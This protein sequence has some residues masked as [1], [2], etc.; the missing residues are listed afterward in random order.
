M[1]YD[2][3]NVTTL[4]DD[5]EEVY[6]SYCSV[7]IY[8]YIEREKKN[9]VGSEIGGALEIESPKIQAPAK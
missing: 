5:T 8:T 1:T 2:P 9:T 3:P 7:Y 4:V 6:H